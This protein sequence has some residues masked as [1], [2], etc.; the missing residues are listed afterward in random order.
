MSAERSCATRRQHTF[1]LRGGDMG[2]ARNGRV[3]GNELRATTVVA[4]AAAAALAWHT[5][6]AR[7]ATETWVG[8]ASGAVWDTAANWSPAAVPVS[9]DTGQFNGNTAGTIQVGYVN[10]IGGANGV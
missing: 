1:H 4:A 5:G 2:T 6:S 7:A 8:A 3:K 9:G 10:G